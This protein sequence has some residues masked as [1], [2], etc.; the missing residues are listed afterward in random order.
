MKFQERGGTQPPAGGHCLSRTERTDKDT[1]TGVLPYAPTNTYVD[2]SSIPRNDKSGYKIK[3]QIATAPVGFAMTYQDTGYKKKGRM[4]FTYALRAT[5][6]CSPPTNTY[7]D[8]SSIPRN[9]KSGYK[10]KEQIATAPVGFAMT[11]QDTGYKKKGECDLPM[12]FAL[13]YTARPYEH[14]R[15]RFQHSSQRQIWIQDKRADR[16]SP[17]GASR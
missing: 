7:V 1:K 5:V 3:E 14:I 16:H 11:Y 15:G 9:D 12:R 10:I 4:R 17:C 13:R 2:V 6:H 8:V